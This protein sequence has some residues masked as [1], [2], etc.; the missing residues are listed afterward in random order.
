[1]NEPEL[2][3]V[4]RILGFLVP[5]FNF[6]TL[7]FCVCGCKFCFLFPVATQI[8]FPHPCEN[9]IETVQ[10][11]YFLKPK[12]SFQLKSRAHCPAHPAS[13]VWFMINN[14]CGIYVPGFSY[15]F[16]FQIPQV[17][18]KNKFD[19]SLWSQEGTIYTWSW[20][21]ALS[22]LVTLVGLKDQW[23]KSRWNTSSPSE[24]FRA[25]QEQ[26]S[27][28][29]VFFYWP[30]MVLFTQPRETIHY[31]CRNHTKGIKRS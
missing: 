22:T 19:Y 14:S 6:F 30:A 13:R 15:V 11:I 27:S 28:F 2:W 21:L 7:F 23:K 24:F 4:C 10:L 17:V 18:F 31:T 12:H 26:G 25:F 1:M 20:L 5:D 29:W 3:T 8:S 16:P 9:H